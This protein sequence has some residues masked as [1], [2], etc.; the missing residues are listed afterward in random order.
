VKEEPEDLLD[1]FVQT[2]CAAVCCR[3][4]VGLLSRYKSYTWHRHN[5]AANEKDS[6]FSTFTG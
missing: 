6:K 2:H 4:V 3:K 5:E 1:P